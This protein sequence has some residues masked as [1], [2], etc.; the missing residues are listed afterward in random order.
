MALLLYDEYEINQLVCIALQNN[1]N[2]SKLFSQIIAGDEGIEPPTADLE[3]AVI[4]LN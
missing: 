4:P 3:A 1:S 2:S